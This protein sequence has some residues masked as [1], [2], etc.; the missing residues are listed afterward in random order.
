MSIMKNNA[1]KFDDK[2]NEKNYNRIF[3]SNQNFFL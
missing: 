2:Y 1:L 3:L